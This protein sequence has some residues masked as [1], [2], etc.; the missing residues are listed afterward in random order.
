[1]DMTS[2]Q[3]SNTPELEAFMEGLGLKWDN[4][5]EK[6]A[7]PFVEAR[8]GT[9]NLAAAMYI[10][11]AVQQIIKDSRPSYQPKGNDMWPEIKVKR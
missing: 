7:Y 11:Q 6:Y 8:S 10:H 2:T 4:C 1:M 3:T 9:L 5:L